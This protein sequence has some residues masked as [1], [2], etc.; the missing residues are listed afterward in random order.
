MRPEVNKASP[1]RNPPLEHL[2]TGPGLSSVIPRH[3]DIQRLHRH[4]SSGGIEPRMELASRN[5]ETSIFEK[6][7][8]RN[9]PT[10][11]EEVSL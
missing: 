7:L 9:N 5:K 11:V 4:A 3:V 8:V 2:A 10:S 6:L 1:Q